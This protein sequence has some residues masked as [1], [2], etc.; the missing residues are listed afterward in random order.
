MYIH[1]VAFMLPMYLKLKYVHACVHI[2]LK[3]QYTTRVVSL[4][5]HNYVD[6]YIHTYVYIHNYVHRC[7]YVH[8]AGNNGWTLDM[9]ILTRITDCLNSF[10]LARQNV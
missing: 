9:C 7:L 6:A 5:S 3:G 10:A 8:N 1:T 2:N 4:C